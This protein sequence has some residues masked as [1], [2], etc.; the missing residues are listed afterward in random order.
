VYGPE[1]S[2]PAASAT[3]AK[4]LEPLPVDPGKEPN[5]LFRLLPKASIS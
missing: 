2:I 1:G 5:D 3:V 4:I